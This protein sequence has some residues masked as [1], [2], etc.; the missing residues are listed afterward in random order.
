MSKSLAVVKLFYNRFIRFGSHLRNSGTEICSLRS[1]NPSAGHHRNWRHTNRENQTFLGWHRG[2]RT[3]NINKWKLNHEMDD[4][5]KRCGRIPKG[6]DK[7]YYSLGS[8]NSSSHSA[9]IKKQTYL[10]D[11]TQSYNCHLHAVCI[12]CMLYVLT[13][14]LSISNYN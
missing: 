4:S 11:R 9:F 8:L 3:C 1:W 13:P 5:Q 10:C 6:T 7:Y 14:V 2:E 12:K